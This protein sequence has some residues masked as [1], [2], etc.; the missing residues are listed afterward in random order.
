MS[1]VPEVTC[2]GCGRRAACM[3]MRDGTVYKP[4]AWKYPKA[5]APLSGVCGDCQCRAEAADVIERVKNCKTVEEYEAIKR[6]IGLGD[7][8]T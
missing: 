2:L 8:P 4:F 3:R 1:D 5:D 6:S 7:T